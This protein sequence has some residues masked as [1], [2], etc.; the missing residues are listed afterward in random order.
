MKK[1]ISKN[2][3]LCLFVMA[4]AMMF[5]PYSKVEAAMDYFYVVP[6]YVEAVPYGTNA[7]LSVK[8][9]YYDDE[10]GTRTDVTGSGKYTFQWCY[11]SEDTFNAA[12]I[13]GQ[14][15]NTFTVNNVTSF[16]RYI[17]KVT[18]ATSGTQSCTFCVYPD[19]E[20]SVQSVDGDNAFDVEYGAK[21]TLTV[22][23]YAK[24]FDGM[25]Y[26]L[27][28]T[29]SLGVFDSVE[30]ITPAVKKISDTHYQVSYTVEKKNVSMDSYRV[31]ATDCYGT[32]QFFDFYLN[33]KLKVDYTPNISVQPG[34]D[35]A[36]TVK[37]SISK[38]VDSDYDFEYS[39]WDEDDNIIE[40]ATSSS[41]TLKNVTKDRQIICG[42]YVYD[43]DGNFIDAN[44]SATFNIKV[45]Q[46]APEPPAPTPE[47]QAP[48][49]EPP[50]AVGT[51]TTVSG[52]TF[53]VNSASTVEV[54][55]APKTKSVTIPDTVVVNGQTMK[56]TSIAANV[57]KNNKKITKVVIGKNITKI[58]KNA[59]Y[60]CTKLKKIT[61]KSK[62]LKSIGKNAFKKAGTKSLKIVFPKGKKKAYKKLLKKGSLKF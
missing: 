18:D 57:F 61:I 32:P 45:V 15:T 50:A 48:T 41:Y 5:L 14:T 56:V 29:D 17:V 11:Y 51:T 4:M 10:N 39:W 19:N 47:P 34:Q 31:Q 38:D 27:L 33:L 6:D 28:K 1:M 22:D 62:K 3:V 54:T 30:N 25:K 43:K 21:E 26:A 53:K 2:V 16:Q 44:G 9:Y 40:G 52:T 7:D 49:P 12:P 36:M 23:V 37:P 13:T 35:A 20:L 60:K 55:K 46:P 42:I 8:V 24:K 59:F 58:G